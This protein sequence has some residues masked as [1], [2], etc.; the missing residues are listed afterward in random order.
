MAWPKGYTAPAD[1][2][3]LSPPNP[4]EPRRGG[5]TGFGVNGPAPPATIGKRRR[6]AIFARRSPRW[7]AGETRTSLDRFGAARRVQCLAGA[8]GGGA[9]EDAAELAG[10]DPT[11]PA[12]GAEADGAAPE[13]TGVAAAL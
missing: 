5:S 7:T 8:C 1:R 2:N 4:V 6:H 13:W 11:A 9:A 12:W 3:G 10:A